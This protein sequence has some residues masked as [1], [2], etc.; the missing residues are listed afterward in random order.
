MKTRYQVD[1]CLEFR[2]DPAAGIL[3]SSWR[4]FIMPKTFLKGIVLMSSLVIQLDEETSHRNY[5]IYVDTKTLE[6]VNRKDLNQAMEE[7][8]PACIEH[9]VTKIAIRYPDNQ[10]GERAMDYFVERINESKCNIKAQLFKDEQPAT[11]WL[12]EKE[13]ASKYRPPRNYWT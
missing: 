10:F 5:G 1:K 4:G 2:P 8:M 6:V 3:Y 9:R 7:L 11:K 12:Q 13:S